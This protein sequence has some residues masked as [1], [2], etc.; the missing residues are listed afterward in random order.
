MAGEKRFTRIPPESTGDRLYMIHTAEIEYKTFNSVPGGTT[1]HVWQIGERYDIAGFGG[2]GKVHV[3][4][5]FDRG[6]GTGILAVHYNKTAKF[7]NFEPTQNS[8]IS[9]ESEGA[10]AQVESFYDVYVPAQNIMGYDNPEYGLNIDPL[11]SA[12]V[13]FAEGE[14]Q[15][16][17]WGKLRTSG[18]TKLGDYVF[19]DESVLDDNFSRVE[20]RGG[21][22]N[23]WETTAFVTYDNTGKYVDVGVRNGNDLSTATA[24]TY[25]HYI[26]GS[27]HLF[28][29]TCVF[30]GAGTVN[31]PQGQGVS[32]RFGTFD[33]F[34]G[35]MFHVGPDGVL[36]LEQ[37]NSNS[38]SKYDK[39]LACSDANTATTLGI[40]RF[41]KD[42]LD[43]TRGAL[44]PSGMIL[45]L[46]KNNQYW[47]DCQWH[48][49]GR[50]RFGVFHNGQ[51]VVVHEYYHNNRYDLP[52]NQTISLP[53]CTA[54]YAYTQSEIDAS[55]GTQAGN[56]FNWN[57]LA[58]AVGK[59]AN[60]DV[61]TRVFSQAMWTETDINL[62]TIG[63]PKAFSTGHLGVDGTGFQYMFSLRVKP[64]ASD[65][66]TTNHSLI[67]PTRVAVIS[68][69]NDVDS[70]GTNRD[71]I[72]HW[73]MSTNT[74]HHNHNWSDI[75]GTNMQVSYNGA[76]YETND[77][78]KRL[79]ED[80][81]N[82]RGEKVLTDTFIDFQYG[83]W[84]NASDDG[85]TTFE[86]LSAI[87]GSDAGNLT[88]NATTA[89]S[90][91]DFDNG[92]PQVVNVTSTADI[93][94]GTLVSHPNMATPEHVMTVID[95][96]SFTIHAPLSA[97]FTGG[98]TISFTKP[99]TVTL[100]T[101]NTNGW[102]LSEPYTKT[103]GPNP[104]YNKAID[105]DGLTLSTDEVY[106]YFTGKTTAVL[107][108]DKTW[109]TP[110]TSTGTYSG[111]DAQI[112]GFNGP[113]YVISFYAHEQSGGVGATAYQDPKSMFVLEWKEI[114]Q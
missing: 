87:D 44:N 19:S 108:A 42:R 41:N 114:I 91:E 68:Y 94:A 38:G 73:R 11:G 100:D 20:T 34:N 78:E 8:N 46:T 81:Y 76:N 105:F 69:D 39:L 13:T 51:R 107:Y 85:G 30:P 43:G 58:G 57:A 83:A 70:T 18:A 29:G 31:S 96:N 23:S 77:V 55:D 5:V 74:I 48:G 54:T 103:F 53:V 112:Y 95:A 102:S 2:D 35:F 98:E 12:Q 65:G 93:A 7:E 97:D 89:V 67:L 75:E 66:V 22:A 56:N 4:G 6:D 82:G 33:A 32:R 60:I 36:Y 61:Q 15:L 110:V 88:A 86:P 9:Y 49:A 10:V 24:K 84:K 52:M 106:F 16:D 37:R 113:E 59:S 26:A 25:H 71:A 17:A 111:S 80:M 3:H 47:I 90:Q 92:T 72:V 1:N 63:K 40:D 50:V 14:P 45:D 21:G 27:S 62:Q 104:D 28:M 64:L 99:V 109:A 101:T 79:L